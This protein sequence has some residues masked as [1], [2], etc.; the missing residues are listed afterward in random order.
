MTDKEAEKQGWYNRPLV[1]YFEDGHW[2]CPQ[3]DDEGNDAGALAATGEVETW[4]VISLG[5][6]K[7]NLA[8]LVKS[9]NA[10]MR[11]NKITDT[12]TDETDKIPSGIKE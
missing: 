7:G 12:G 9:H 2:M 6:E 4:P 3:M 8:P 11:K 5:F 1:L 10:A